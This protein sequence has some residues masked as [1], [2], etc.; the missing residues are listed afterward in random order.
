MAESAVGAILELVVFLIE[1]TVSTFQGII[2]RFGA[3]VESLGVVSSV[4]GPVAFVVSLVIVGIV[5]F[6]LAKILFGAG[7]KLIL[8]IVVA[9]VLV[10]VLVLGAV[11]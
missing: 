10:Y 2:E 3:L 1:T 4:G 5:G 9:L 8:L 7:I 6:F 11:I